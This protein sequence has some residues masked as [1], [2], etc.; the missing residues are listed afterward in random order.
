MA[1]NAKERQHLKARAHALKPVIMVGN[2]GVTEA[3]MKEVD[4]ALNDHELIK[5]RVQSLDRDE[6]KALLEAI[7]VQA[8]AELV[9]A[10]GAIGVYFRK[11]QK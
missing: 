9:Q 4:R 7:R 3:V 5:I 2:N 6:R 11:R 8:G 10:I 1:L